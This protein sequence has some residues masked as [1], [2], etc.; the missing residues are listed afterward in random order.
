[1]NSIPSWLR[2][3]VVAAGL[4]AAQA[5][6]EIL[7]VSMSD[8]TIVAY[9]ISLGTAADIENSRTVFA[10]TNLDNPYGIAFDAAG[11]LHVANFAANSIST[12]DPAGGFVS[13][14][15]TNLD[16]PLGLAFDA[17]GN[18]HAANG[19]GNTISRFDP[20]GGFVSAIT[21]NLD[22]PFGLAFDAAGNLYAANGMDST[23]ATFDPAGGFVSGMILFLDGPTGLAFDSAGNL[24]AANGESTTISIFDPAGG[25]VSAITTDG[26]VGLAFDSA[27]NLYAANG[28]ITSRTISKFDSSGSFLFSWSTGAAA[29]RFLAVSGPQ[30]V[31]EIDPGCLCGAAAVVAGGLGLVERRRLKRRAAC[32]ASMPAPVR[33]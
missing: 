19:S 23:I 13:A 22:G 28:S 12:F 24:W 30:P 4:V 20:A 9:D 16:G 11:N 32:G 2:L 8:D 33:G 5:R 21:T 26:P 6:A 14:I 3:A 7:Y 25:L 15:T 27:G 10:S 31:P 17:A 29:P 18:L 1:M